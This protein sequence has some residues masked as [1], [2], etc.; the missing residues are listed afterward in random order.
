MYALSIKN[1]YKSRNIIFTEDN[2]NLKFSLRINEDKET[3]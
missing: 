1:S 2:I 3:Y